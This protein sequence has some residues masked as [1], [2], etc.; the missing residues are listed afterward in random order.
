MSNFMLAV[1]TPSNGF[2]TAEFGMSLVNLSLWVGRRQ[3]PG[4]K[5]QGL[6]LVHTR[7]SILPQLRRKQVEIALKGGASHILFIDS[8]QEFPPDTAHRLVNWRKPVVACNIAVKTV[9]SAPTARTKGEWVGGHPVYS[10]EQTGLEQ[11]WRVGCGVM[12]VEAEVFKKIAKPWFM[13]AWDEEMQDEIGEDWWFCSQCE[14]A[15]IPIYVDHGLSLDI[16]HVGLHTFTHGEVWL[17]SDEEKVNGR[18]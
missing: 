11:V 12:M 13:C 8:D 18:K 4:Y 14:K 2:W 3:V 9:P 7:G 16:G 17:P 1:C 15:G 5:G 6:R 10:N